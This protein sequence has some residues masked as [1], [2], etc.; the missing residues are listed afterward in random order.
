MMIASLALVLSLA[1]PGSDLD[2]LPLLAGGIKRVSSYDRKEGNNDF[3]NVFPGQSLVLTDL[4]EPGTIQRIF[5][6]V[7][8]DD[9]NHLRTLL[10]RAFWDDS[11]EPSIDTPLGDFFALGHGKY[12]PVKSEP[13]VTGNRRGMTCYWPMPFKKSALMVLVNEGVGTVYRVHYQIDYLPGEPAEGSG[14]FHALYSQRI[15]SPGDVNFLVLHTEGRGKYVGLVLSIVLG[16]DGWFGEGDERIYVDGEEVPYVQGTGLDDMFGCAWGFQKGFSGPYIGTPVAGDLKRG[17]EFTGYRFLLR[18]PVT[19]EKSIDVYLEH[20]GVRYSAGVMV[21]DAMSRRDEYYSVAYWYQDKPK[22]T[23]GRMPM[24]SERISG[25]KIHMVEAEHLVPLVTCVD[26]LRTVN[27]DSETVVRFTPKAVGDQA[28]F[29]V[30]ISVSGWYRISGHFTRSSRHGIYG[31]MVNDDTV[32][33][34]IDFYK[35]EGGTGREYLQ[36][37]DEIQLGRVQL[38]GGMHLFRFEA[39][40]SNEKAGGMLLGIDSLLIRPAPRDGE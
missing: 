11:R 38:G 20:V 28:V 22:R 25:D 4:K 12:Y 10:L 26:R 35:G 33:E 24:S 17:A 27:V 5:I 16:E 1:L 8:S 18:D 2:D 19:F 23:F 3:F 21:G 9:P 31:F 15:L 30:P 40:G 39:K 13:I 32:A 14:Y 34:A 36:R 6:K 7:D 37:S 29:N